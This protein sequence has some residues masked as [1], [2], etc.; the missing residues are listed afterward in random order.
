MRENHSQSGLD[1]IKPLE[2]RETVSLVYIPTDLT[3]Q[4]KLSWFSLL[5]SQLEIHKR[6]SL[7]PSRS[8]LIST[9]LQELAK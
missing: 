6:Q 2:V 5:D 4:W 9:A 7:M 3:G 8:H 1:D